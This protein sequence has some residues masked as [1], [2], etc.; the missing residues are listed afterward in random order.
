MTSRPADLTSY[1]GG[2]G[3]ATT[4]SSNVA[5]DLSKF[6]SPTQRILGV[7]RFNIDGGTVPNIVV[8][9]VNTPLVDN[10]GLPPAQDLL[11]LAWDGLAHRWFVAY[12]AAKETGPQN[13]TDPDAPMWGPFPLQQTPTEPVIPFSAGPK[14][15]V[16]SA[17][18][19]QPGKRVDLL[20]W[21]DL[22]VPDGHVLIVGIV[23]FNGQTEN[24]AWSFMS[25]ES[26][27]VSVVGSAPRQEI[28]VS[29]GWK[30]PADPHCCPVRTYRFVVARTLN[31]PGFAGPSYFDLKNPGGG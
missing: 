16:V 7:Y 28:A 27:S 30:T 15:L 14:G 29:T 6:L 1:N 20:Y 21:S 17:L 10:I 25:N 26:G 13:F 5:P 23:H 3:P 9:T 2:S 19:D 11:V 4:Q 18:R 31:S 12:D 22:E 8:T 24:L